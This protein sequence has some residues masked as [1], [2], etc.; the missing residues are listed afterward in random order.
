MTYPPFYHLTTKRHVKRILSEGLIPSLGKNRQTADD[1]RDGV[2]LC[3]MNSVP[4]WQILLKSNALIKIDASYIDFQLLNNRVYSVYD[5]YWYKCA[6]PPE[7]LSEV[8]LPPVSNDA[9]RDI[10]EEIFNEIQIACLEIAL[11][12]IPAL[13]P[14]FQIDPEEIEDYDNFLMSINL[15]ASLINPR[16]MTQEEYRKM[17]E[18]YVQNDCVT[19]N[20]LVTNPLTQRDVRIWELIPYLPN[21]PIETHQKEIEL[22]NFINKAYTEKTRMYIP[23]HSTRIQGGD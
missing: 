16:V 17:L 19:M 20:T 18:D 10:A 11:L 23:T 22:Y 7:A 8:P 15:S 12:R 2:F 9:M 5:E 1:E 4:Y 14:D 21:T 13:N 3:H 6:I